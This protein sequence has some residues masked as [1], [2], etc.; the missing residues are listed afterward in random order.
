MEEIIQSIKFE[1]S[2]N[3]TTNNQAAQNQVLPV[4]TVPPSKI[5][6]FMANLD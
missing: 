2:R 1:E 5:E 3:Q 4:M 6:N